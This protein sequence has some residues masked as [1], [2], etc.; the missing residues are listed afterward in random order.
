MHCG[1]KVIALIPIS[2]CNAAANSVFACSCVCAVGL[3]RPA[4]STDVKPE[5]NDE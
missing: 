2:C 4:A 1:F 3:Q 5:A